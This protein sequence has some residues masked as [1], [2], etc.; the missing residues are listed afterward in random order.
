MSKIRRTLY[1]YLD[2]S[3]NLD[4]T[5]KGTEYFVLSAM[6]TFN[7]AESQR[8]LQTL[9]YD[10]L[11][12][13]VDAEFFHAS[14]DMQEVRNEVFRAI[15]Q[16]VNLKFNFVYANKRTMPVSQQNS[17]DLYSETAQ[18]V[19]RSCLNN[20]S[21]N[22]KT[23]KV[24]VIFDKTL[25]NKEN[26]ALQKSMKPFLKATNKPF[27]LYFH[28]VKSDFNAQIADYA[29]WALYRGLEAGDK[30]AFSEIKNFPHTIVEVFQKSD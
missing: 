26:S 2:E 21:V 29:C 4:F 25:T 7:P 14:P 30:R 6:M 23:E 9:K 17:I 24:I 8:S 13:G 5:E 16:S 22:S 10:L 19:L 18:V 12:R 27:Y 1:I 3:G 11:E 20:R 28:Q 15:N